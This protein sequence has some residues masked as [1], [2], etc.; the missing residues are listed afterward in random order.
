M[1]HFELLKGIMGIDEEARKTAAGRWDELTHPPKSLGKLESIVNQLAGI[2]RT[3]EIEYLDGAIILFAADHG[4]AKRGVSAYPREVTAQMVQN[5]VDN[6]A[7]I[8]VLT[9]NNDIHLELVDIGVACDIPPS[10][11]VIDRKVAYG[12]KDFSDEPAMSYTE[13]IEAINV[14]CE[15]VRKLHDEGINAI[16]FGEMGIGNTTPSAALI[17]LLSSYPASEVVGI[18]SGIDLETQRYK[19]KL[20]DEAIKMHTLFHKAPAEALRCVGGLEIAGMVGGM[21]MCAA[22]RI[23]IFVDGVIASAAALVAAAIEPKV[24]DFMIATHGSA[25]KG[26]AFAMRRLGLV[27]TLMLDMRLGEGT[28]AVLGMAMAK[29]AIALYNK[30]AKFSE[31]PV[32][33]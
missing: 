22:L 31:S 29:Q 25:D 23:P 24:T 1:E 5:F 7:A 16:G 15:M 33:V 17:S 4:I 12:T 8:N 28:G 13:C 18:G 30:M 21:M 14:G 20:I 27:P 6:G 11:R 9:S 26:Q 10:D 32:K 2:Y 19:A 3:P